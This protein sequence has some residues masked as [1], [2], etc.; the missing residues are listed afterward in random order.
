MFKKNEEGRPFENGIF[1]KIYQLCKLEKMHL[2]WSG[3]LG[4]DW[5][6]KSNLNFYCMPYWQF[7]VKILPN[8]KTTRLL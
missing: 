5:I 4:G 8:A 1:E 3:I 6:G 2:S 7:Y